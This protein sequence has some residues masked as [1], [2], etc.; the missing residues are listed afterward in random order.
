[1]RRGLA[2]VLIVAAV[3]PASAGLAAET[4]PG[5]ATTV[6]FDSETIATSNI[7]DDQS[8]LSD[9]GLHLRGLL[10]H[11]FTSDAGTWVVKTTLDA[12]H[13]RDHDFA[14]TDSVAIELDHA[15][16][17]SA[18]VSVSTHL[19]YALA[20]QGDDLVVGPLV[21]GLRQSIGSYS[22]GTA[23]QVRL[24]ADTLAQLSVDERYD[25]VG[26]A[27]FELPLPDQKVTPD[28][29]VLQTTLGVAHA[30]GAVK[31][32]LIAEMTDVALFQQVP[33]QN[34]V[35]YRNY[36]LRGRFAI[37]DA[38]GWSL[39]GEIGIR[40]LED[41]VGIYDEARPI[42]ALTV[43]KVFAGR[44]SLQAALT[45]DFDAAQTDDPL[46]TYRQR[47]ELEGQ[48]RVA[49]AI[50]VG[51]G[52]YAALGDNLLLENKDRRWGAYGALAYTFN[53]KLS[54]LV[55]VDYESRRRTIIDQDDDTLSG[56]IGLQARL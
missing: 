6:E 36:A 55:R 12:T 3:A 40:R 26:A 56:R 19:G 41:G 22:A 27:R 18:P 45:R 10:S 53:P 46:A 34:A 8:G 9:L 28:R 4:Q 11:A 31:T 47:V 51:A 17:V 30:F 21:L 2:F 32:A 1:M 42:Y 25:D 43:A 14:D 15:T 52:I 38:A 20:D 50:L 29:N 7:F 16:D 44:Y 37:D 23:I 24:P 54:L 13:Y 49:D 35:P 48:A 33:L 5:A 39:A